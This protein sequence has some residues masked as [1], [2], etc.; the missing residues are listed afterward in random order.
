MTVIAIGNLADFNFLF[1]DTLVTTQDRNGKLQ[2]IGVVNKIRF[3]SNFDFFYTGSGPSEIFNLVHIYFQNNS[4][5]IANQTCRERIVSYINSELHTVGGVGYQP[6]DLT[7]AYIHRNEVGLWD[8]VYNPNLTNYG[9]L[10]AN[11][12]IRII[13][14]NEYKILWF[15]YDTLA[16]GL[17]LNTL[18]INNVNNEVFREMQN[19][20]IV[21]KRR[22]EQD[23][24]PNLSN[25]SAGIISKPIGNNI[26]N[27]FMGEYTL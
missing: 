26:I 17:T 14:E 15:G 9:I 21:W 10:P 23:Q 16:T 4:F 25:Y 13:S 5:D 1:V 12:D 2:R 11:D 7:V 24:L 27:R 6:F 20:H 3:S 8:I 19:I 18:N 22:M